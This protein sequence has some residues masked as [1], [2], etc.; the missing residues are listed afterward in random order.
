MQQQCLAAL[1]DV[2]AI[3]ACTGRF[4]AIAFEIA[5][6]PHHEIQVDVVIDLAAGD[7]A[8]VGPVRPVDVNDLAAGALG[9][10]RA[11]PFAV[12]LAAAVAMPGAPAV[13]PPSRAGAR[14][15]PSA[16]EAAQA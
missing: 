1:D 12:S 15:Q 11:S 8:M 9:G 6:G 13:L 16:R 2:A 3:A 7:P 14:A 10:R 4:H 5:T